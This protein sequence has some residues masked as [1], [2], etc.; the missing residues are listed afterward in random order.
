[1]LRVHVDEGS[2]AEGLRVVSADRVERDVD[3][4]RLFDH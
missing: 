3:A 2:T 1:M 4:A